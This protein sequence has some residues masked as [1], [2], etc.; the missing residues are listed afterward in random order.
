[1]NKNAH[2]SENKTDPTS[3]LAFINFL[4]NRARCTKRNI[5]KGRY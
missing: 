1:M 2:K 5:H 4:L 3:N